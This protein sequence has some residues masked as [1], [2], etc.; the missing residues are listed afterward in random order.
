MFFC[1]ID[2][3]KGVFWGKNKLFYLSKGSANMWV[4]SI[5]I[6]SI[7]IASIKCLHLLMCKTALSGPEIL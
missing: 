6:V 5:A 2:T 1:L 7:E 4:R 3:N